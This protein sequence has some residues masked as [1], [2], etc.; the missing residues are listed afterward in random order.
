M[1]RFL[2][3]DILRDVGVFAGAGIALMT[4]QRFQK[5]PVYECLSEHPRVAASG[6]GRILHSLHKMEQPELFH[7]ILRLC[8]TFLENVS[9]GNTGSDGFV[10]NRLAAQIPERITELCKR[11]SHSRDLAV[12]TRAMDFERDD[13]DQARAICDDMV[14][15][16]LLESSPYA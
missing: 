15:N 9:T 14:R 13:L 4:F 3:G 1:Q 2:Q 8:D 11:A 7:E 6:F 16:M 5:P 10:A 12:A